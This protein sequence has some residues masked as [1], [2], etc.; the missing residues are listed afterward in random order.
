MAS[1]PVAQA[2]KP[3]FAHMAVGPFFLDWI[4]KALM[5][6]L[7][8][9]Y[10]EFKKATEAD[11]NPMRVHEGTIGVFRSITSCSSPD[12]PQFAR[13]AFMFESS[14]M[15]PLTDYATERSGVLHGESGLGLGSITKFD[16]LKSQ[17]M[18][19]RCGMAYVLSSWT[20]WVR[21]MRS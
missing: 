13:K 11:L 20:I 10:E 5:R 3:G 17:S 4:A 9:S 7:S 14:L 16:V 15:L 2:T 21:L 18:S 6:F 1:S 19:R 8:V 12:T